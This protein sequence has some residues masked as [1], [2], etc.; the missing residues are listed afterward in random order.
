MDFMEY[1]TD[2]GFVIVTVI[3]T[4]TALLLVA[5]RRRRDR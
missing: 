1:F 4:I 3:G 5:S 2:V